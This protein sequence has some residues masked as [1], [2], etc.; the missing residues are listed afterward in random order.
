MYKQRATHQLEKNLFKSFI[1]DNDSEKRKRYIKNW[2]YGN[3][4]VKR[5]IPKD[6]EI[7]EYKKTFWDLIHGIITGDE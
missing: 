2:L 3:T 1:D 6:R 4:I 7:K 5:S